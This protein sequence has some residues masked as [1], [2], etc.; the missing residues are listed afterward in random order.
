LE[1]C[2]HTSKEIYKTNKIDEVYDKLV[3]L[4]WTTIKFLQIPTGNKLIKQDAI[5]YI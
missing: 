5:N 3:E 2:K 4:H 1:H